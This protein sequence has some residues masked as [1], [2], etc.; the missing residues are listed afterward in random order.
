MPAGWADVQQW[1]D[2]EGTPPEV[3]VADD[4]LLRLMYTSGTESRPKGAMLSSRSLMWQ[5]VSCIIDGG[6]DGD[7][8]EVHCHAA[9]P[10]RAAGLL[11][12]AR[13]IPRCHEHR[14]AGARPVRDL[15]DDRV[16]ACD[17]AVLPAD[18][19]DRSAAVTAVRPD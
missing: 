10:L 16:A 11:P 8:V 18:G 9:V 15:E 19:M 7:D 3:A 6:M 14:A 13:H 5:Y 12:R 1:I 4:D 2:R 17:E